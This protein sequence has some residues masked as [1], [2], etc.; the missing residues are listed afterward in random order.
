MNP[1]GNKL[2]SVL[3]FPLRLAYRFSRGLCDVVFPRSC[4][5]TGKALEG[6]K[7]FFI[8]E[9]GVEK[10]CFIHAEGACVRCGVAVAECGQA[11]KMCRECLAGT[12]AL[13]IG[14][15]RSVLRLDHVSRPI[16]FALKYW[17]NPDIAGDMALLAMSSR[18]FV[19]H[20]SDAILVPVPLHKKRFRKRGYNQSLCLAK[21]FAGIATGA[22]V[23]PLLRRI[24]ET[25]TQTCLDVSDRRKNVHDAF[26]LNPGVKLDSRKRYVLIDDVFTTGSTLSECARVL[27]LHGAVKVDAATFAHG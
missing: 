18:G 27:R 13:Q 25:G 19:E 4:V 23:E 8:S 22:R 14:A 2:A 15:S 10:L 1:T 16:I 26:A 20:L 12:N 11:V 9:E 21:A 3:R 17:K 5:I 6:G 24:H 7:M